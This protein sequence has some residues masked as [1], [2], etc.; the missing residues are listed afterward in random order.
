M[1]DA[2]GWQ[3]NVLV[4]VSYSPMQSTALYGAKTQRQLGAMAASINFLSMEMVDAIDG[5]VTPLLRAD[6]ADAVGIMR[7]KDRNAP[8]DVSPLTTNFFSS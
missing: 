2:M 5:Q 7:R 6:S 4:L 1:V 8:L 3:V